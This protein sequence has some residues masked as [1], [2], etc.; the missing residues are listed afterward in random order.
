L[1]RDILKTCFET[2]DKPT[3]GQFA[4]GFGKAHELKGH[5]TLIK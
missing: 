1:P 3:Q 5:V 4:W 2:G